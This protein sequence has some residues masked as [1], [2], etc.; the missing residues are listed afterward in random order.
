M[1]APIRERDDVI[2]G[3]KRLRNRL[4]ADVAAGTVTLDDRR[5][6]DSFLARTDTRR[7]FTGLV[8]RVRVA[9]WRAVARV[10]AHRRG[11][12]LAAM[13][14][15]RTADRE[16]ERSY[17]DG[18]ATLQAAR[19]VP[20]LSRTE[21]LPT[22]SGLKSCVAVEALPKEYLHL[23]TLPIPRLVARRTPRIARVSSPRLAASAEAIARESAA[24]MS[25]A[26]TQNVAAVSPV[27]SMADVAAG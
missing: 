5:A 16:D 8:M 12:N 27:P 23:A 4:Q 21:R 24:C 26:A 20:A 2:D 22:I 9:L 19:F 14:T 11:K 7:S 1:Q 10:R 15:R 17:R 18:R 13:A 25:D 3:D 6:V